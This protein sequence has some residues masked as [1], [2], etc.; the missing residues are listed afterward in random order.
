MHKTYQSDDSPGKIEM[1]RF[2]IVGKEASQK[3]SSEPIFIRFALGLVSAFWGRR[4][5]E[6]VPRAKVGFTVKR[7]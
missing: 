2:R 6:I 7:L 4:N 1:S 3:D 5:E